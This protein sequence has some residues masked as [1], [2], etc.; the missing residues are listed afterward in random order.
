MGEA[1][2]REALQDRGIQNAWTLRPQLMRRSVGR[3]HCDPLPVLLTGTSRKM[4]RLV[5]TLLLLTA[6][7]RAQAQ[8]MSA[9]LPGDASGVVLSAETGRPIPFSLLLFAVRDSTLA[10][11]DT[12]YLGYTGR[13]SP[14]H[15][16]G[17]VWAAAAACP[18]ARRGAIFHMVPRAHGDTLHPL[19]IRVSTRGCPPVNGEREYRGHY[20]G[21]FEASDFVPCG[22][23]GRRDSNWWVEVLP[24]ARHGIH[25]GEGDD[26][27][28]A[29]R[30]YVRWRGVLSPPGR[31]GHMSAATHQLAVTQ[32]LEVHRPTLADCGPAE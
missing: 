8:D 27:G 19:V 11:P 6:A 4:K 5:L 9:P 29:T 13:F 24:E 20:T 23:E 17:P 10:Y 31:Y 14:S 12:A 28:N 22:N 30:Y 26:V 32:V 21:C 2:Q 3:R 16:S 1:L 25:W 7:P 15:I 18:G